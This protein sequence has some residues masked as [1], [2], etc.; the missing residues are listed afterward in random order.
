MEI[1]PENKGN[2]NKKLPQKLLEILVCPECKSE[3]VYDQEN[4]ELLCRKSKL[5]FAVRNGIPIMLINEARK[6]KD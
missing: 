5:A 3:L 4:N 2:Q 6:I 1:E